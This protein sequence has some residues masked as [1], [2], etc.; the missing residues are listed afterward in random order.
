M[1]FAA[2]DTRSLRVRK[3]PEASG[4][5][6][7]V[8]PLIPAEQPAPLSGLREDGERT[9]QGGSERQ[10]RLLVSLSDDVQDRGLAVAPD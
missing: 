3:Q 7:Q 6:R 4:A 5:A 1:R 9:P 8:F 10:Q 2:G